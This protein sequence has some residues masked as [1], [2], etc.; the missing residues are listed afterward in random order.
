VGRSFPLALAP[1]THEN[2]ASSPIAVGVVAR[3]V[4]RLP[5]S[6]RRKADRPSCVAQLGAASQRRNVTSNGQ[7]L[8][9][10]IAINPKIPA[11][12][13]VT[14]TDRSARKPPVSNAFFRSSAF[15]LGR[16]GTTLALSGRRRGR[17][18]LSP[19]VA[20]LGTNSNSIDHPCPPTHLSSVSRCA[21]CA[22]VHP[23]I[24]QGQRYRGYYGAETSVE[25][26]S[27][28]LPDAQPR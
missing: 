2:L 10:S 18:R 25:V 19:G 27:W 1:P 3:V 13:R 15:G 20:T 9:E 17:M 16:K 14:I 11:K 6:R 7:G 21:T 26:G 12:A 23:R 24:C 8:E 28:T 22:H 4:A 5:T